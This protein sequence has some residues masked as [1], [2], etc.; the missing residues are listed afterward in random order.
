MYKRQGLGSCQS[1]YGVD[2]A[3]AIIED[4]ERKVS[5]RRHYGD[6]IGNTRLATL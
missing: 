5:I 1:L 3:P 6:Q 4:I 2:F